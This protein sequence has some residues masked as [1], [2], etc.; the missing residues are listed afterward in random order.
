[1]TPEEKQRIQ[2]TFLKVHRSKPVGETSS[3]FS[4]NVMRQIRN[5]GQENEHID[6]WFS[7]QPV[8]WR[9]ASSAALIAIVLFAYVLQTGFLPEYELA[10]ILLDNTNPLFEFPTNR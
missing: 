10:E 7:F 2:E 6:G 3:H 8:V 4:K 5:L 9:F 1:M